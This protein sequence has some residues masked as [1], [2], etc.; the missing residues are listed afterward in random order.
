VP[1][2]MV[3][4]ICDAMGLIG[5]ADDCCRHILDMVELGVRNLYLMPLQ[6]FVPPQSEMRTFHDIVFPR[7]HHAGLR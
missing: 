2:D 6:T 7:L 1:D 5:T 4:Q 3:A